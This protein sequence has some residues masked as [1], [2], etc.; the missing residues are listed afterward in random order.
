MVDSLD[1]KLINLLMNN[2]R[3]S[4]KVLAQ[5]LG[6]DQSTVRRRTNKLI[7]NGVLFFSVFPNPDVLGF[8]VRAV[9]ALDVASGKVSSVIEALGSREETKWISSTSG[10]YDIILIVWFHSNEEIYDFIEGV[11]GKLE[12]IRN[13]E[14]FIC[15]S[16]SEELAPR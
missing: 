1:Q 13:A 16:K 5:Q 6:V 14:V 15:L 2:S 4:S 11:V 12:G 10:R 3:Q 9:L 8:P 7:R